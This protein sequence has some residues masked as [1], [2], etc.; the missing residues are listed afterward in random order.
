MIFKKLTIQ[1]I[2]SYEDLTIEFPRGSVLLAGDIGSGKTS[3]LLGLQFALFGLQPG[4][5]GASILRQGT[6]NAYACLEID[7][8]G[9]II[10]LE[11]TIK[12][13]KSGGITQDSN[14]INIG[15]TREELSTSE[16][17][18]RVIRLL[19]YPKEFVK[20]SNLLYKFTVYTP[21]EEMKSI[22]QERPEVRLDILRHIF[23]IDRYKRI[24]DNAQILS[25]KL[26]EAVKIKEVLVSELNL[27]KEKFTLENEKKI[28]LVRETNNLNLDYQKLLLRRQEGEDRLTSSQ[29]LID[30]KREL[31]SELGKLTILLQGKRDLETRMKKEVIL[32]QKQIHEKSEFSEERLRSVLELVEKHKRILDEKNSEFLEISSKVSVLDSKKERP[33]ELKEKITS[34]ENCPTCLQAVGQDHKSRIEKQTQYEIEEIDRELEQKIQ[35]KSLLLKEVEKEKEL[36][37]GYEIDKN[38]LQQDKIKYEHQRTIEIKIKSDA[39]ILDRTSNEIS[40]L[41][42]QI[43]ELKVRIMTF[44]QSQQTFD[45]AKKNFQEINEVS[46]IKEITM[47]TK[48]KEL[49]LLRIKLEDLSAEIRV[50]EKVREEINH[51]RGLQDWIQEK[52]IS[53]INLTEKRVMVKLNSEFS[54]I[55]AEWFSMLVSD[56]L[57]VRLDEDF[58]PIITNQDYE[59]DYD[60]LSGGERTAT[61]LAY[62]LSLNQV[63][64]SMLS[65]I[66]TKDVVILDEP[67]DGFATEQIDKMRDIFEQLKAEQ[68]ILVSH[69]EKIEGFVDHVIRVK[70]DGISGIE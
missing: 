48:N 25:Q 33:L 21:Q 53:M 44:D 43:E 39:F 65:Q 29:K 60:F 47:A 32:M 59:I 6:D 40:A 46:R 8:D 57:S 9:E 1:N 51:L 41:N 31:V 27:L 20:K 70:K 30:E 64:N 16:M 7:I 18:D 23:G 69:E 49:E 50:K 63:L 58:T 11:R 38:N 13:S 54:A 68:M 37:R 5:K 14:I 67:T 4:Q 56:S 22:V 66:K 36:V 34:L 3:I 15:A 55:F 28:A 10:T 19:N 42:K 26:K 12:K 62:R 35:Q 24:K 52:F 17:K 2:R 45:L 61:A